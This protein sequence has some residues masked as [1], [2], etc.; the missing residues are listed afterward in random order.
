MRHYYGDFM[1]NYAPNPRGGNGYSLLEVQ[2]FM[3]HAEPK[4]TKIYTSR[5]DIEKVRKDTEKMNEVLREAIQS[6]SDQNFISITNQ[7]HDI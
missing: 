1:I 7:V 5:I 4:S 2:H 6:G 3:R